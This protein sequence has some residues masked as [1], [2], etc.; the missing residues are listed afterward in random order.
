MRNTEIARAILCLVFALHALHVE[1]VQGQTQEPG[2]L[3][4]MLSGV[5]SLL[6]PSAD[7]FVPQPNGS[8]NG[9]NP[10]TAGNA[11]PSTLQFIGCD[12][13]TICYNDSTQTPGAWTCRSQFTG[14]MSICVPTVLGLTV[15]REGD[16]CGCCG[17]VC[18][19]KCSCGCT[20]ARGTPGVMAKF[21]LFFGLVN[22]EQCLEPTVAEAATS[23]TTF[24]ISCSDF[25]AQDG[26][27]TNGGVRR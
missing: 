3:G 18:P 23:F 6:L 25:C 13:E 2:L 11:A 12:R 16:T 10:E 1:G 14:E 24:D 7:E 21:N 5:I 9:N 19:Q 15:G 20:N 26:T 17:G 27:T 8:S 22:F 4:Q